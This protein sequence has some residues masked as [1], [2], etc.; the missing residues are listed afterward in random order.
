MVREL[1]AKGV[2]VASVASSFFERSIQPLQRRV[3]YGYEYRGTAD[4]PRMAKDVPSTEEIMRRVQ[5]I[6]NKVH[7]ELYV[8]KQ[9]NAKDPP[10][11]DDLARFVSHPPLPEDDDRAA[12]ETPSPPWN[13]AIASASHRQCTATRKRKAIITTSKDDNNDNVQQ[14]HGVA[15]DNPEPPRQGVEDE[16]R[17]GSLAPGQASPSA[18]KE[19][20]TTGPKIMAA[21]KGLVIPKAIPL[22][23]FAG[24]SSVGQSSKKSGTE[25]TSRVKTLCLRLNLPRLLR[26]PS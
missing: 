9:F 14:Q 24:K 6:L 11:A 13:D 3:T 23:K 19:A 5:H 12:Q 20:T 8:P 2:T 22:K 15:V 17:E 26:P 7:S 4:P 10:N 16:T 18:T 25:P 21:P 1:K